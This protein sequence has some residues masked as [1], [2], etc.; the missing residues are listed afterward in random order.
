M[1]FF[2]LVGGLVN[3]PHKLIARYR[4]NKKYLPA[5][6]IVIITALL[7]IPL[8]FIPVSIPGSGVNLKQAISGFFINFF[9]VIATYP[10]ACLVLK[11]ASIIRKK[12]IAFIEIFSTWGFS[13]VPTAMF[14]LYLLLTHLFVPKGIMIF[15]TTPFSIILATILVAIFIWK[16]LFYFIEL[17]IVLRENFGG[18]IISSL[19]IIFFFA[20]Y[21]FLVAY[22]LGYKIP[23]L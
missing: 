3:S 10:L 17:R 13:Y 2:K 23:V 9:V 14:L 19:I 11:L 21:Y 5:L 8:M 6:I 20:A 15:G 7:I 16:L 1:Y 22:L 18:M 12:K 4:D